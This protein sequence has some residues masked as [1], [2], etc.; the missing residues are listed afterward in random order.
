MRA[1]LIGWDGATWAY[2]DPLLEEG[3][4]P[5]LAALLSCGIRATLRSTVP[6]YTSVAWPSLV[7]GLSPSG[8]QGIRGTRS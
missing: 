3:A 7:T 8:G 1:L 4:L 5:N 6:P 2:I